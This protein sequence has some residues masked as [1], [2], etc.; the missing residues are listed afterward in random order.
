MGEGQGNSDT[1]EQIAN[2]VSEEQTFQWFN[3]FETTFERHEV[4]EVRNDVLVRKLPACYRIPSE[5]YTP[6]HWHFGLHNRDVLHRSE[7]EDLKIA[8]AAACELGPWDKFCLSVVDD[9]IA[10]LRGYGLDHSEPKFSMRQ[11]QYLL[12]LDALT[13]FLVF[14]YYAFGVT[15][16]KMMQ[17]GARLIALLE[18][19]NREHGYLR[20]DLFL[21]ENQIPIA[22]LT[23]CFEKLIKPNSRLMKQQY[24]L[25][26][27]LNANVCD[28]CGFILFLTKDHLAKIE[29][30]YPQGELEKCPHILACVYRILCGQNLER[31]SRARRITIQSATALKKAGIQIKGIKGVLDEVGFR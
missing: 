30:A 10:V 14:A 3:E 24:M 28:M 15:S 26:M 22:L 21:V 16:V 27:I 9:P 20:V 1:E 5:Q 31:R 8:L 2:F 12:T 19:I 7:P 18:P 13:I 29:K 6:K 17:N 11:V 23:K 25:D 4:R